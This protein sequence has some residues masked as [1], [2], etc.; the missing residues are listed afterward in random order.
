MR[1]FEQSKKRIGA[2]RSRTRNERVGSFVY[3]WN[4]ARCRRNTTG[5]EAERRVK[6][7]R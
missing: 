4:A 2:R 7:G 6:K 5:L 1:S 3:S